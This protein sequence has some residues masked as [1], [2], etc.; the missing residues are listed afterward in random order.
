MPNWFMKEPCIH[1][2]FRR[3]VRPFLR[4]ERAKELAY[5][6]C[7]KYSEFHCHKTLGHDE[8]EDDTMV[9]PTSLACAGFLTMQINQTGASVPDGFTLSD[10]A[11][12]DHYEMVA[13]YQDEADGVWEA[14]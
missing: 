1:C 8:D 12:E 6:A 5:A 9:V 3:D 11:Y 7:N 13:A 4:V 2:P 10:L 14:P